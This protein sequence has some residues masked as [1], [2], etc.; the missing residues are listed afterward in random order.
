MA[1]VLL[2]LPDCDFDPTETGVPWAALQAH[3]HRVVFATPNGRP[4]EADPKMVTGRGLGIFAP[5]LKADGNGRAAYAAM[6]ASETFRHPL[7]YDDVRADD[8]AAVVLPGGHAKGM[9]P[10]LESA[11]LQATVAAFFAQA[12]PVGAIC[13]GVLLAARS[14]APAGK[15]VL[16]GRRTTAL[17]R[18][19]ELGAWALTASYL[20]DYY[21][22][23]PMTVES[24]VKAALASPA[25]FSRGPAGFA[26]D[27]P[28]K[29]GIGFT[30]RDGNYL[31][32]RWPG[33]AHRFAGE[34]AAMVDAA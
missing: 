9:R 10:Y 14:R 19:M 31:S 21:R 32:A 30:V 1:T 34:F 15:S 3:G 25:D 11:L 13:H 16:H 5:F 24:E 2:P 22:T 7:P 29:P 23:Y 33:D 18:M 20:G 4:G 28:A 8:F 17:T 27:T 6:I 26:R 12:K